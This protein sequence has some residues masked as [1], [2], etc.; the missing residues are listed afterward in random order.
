M[1]YCHVVVIHVT[2]GGVEIEANLEAKS[3]ENC[4]NITDT[5]ATEL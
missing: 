2:D 5:T 1:Y 4:Y 3:E